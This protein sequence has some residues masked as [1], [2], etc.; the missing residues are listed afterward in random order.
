MSIKHFAE[1]LGPEHIHL[2]GVSK[3]VDLSGIPQTQRLYKAED[4]LRLQYPELAQ[5]SPSRQTTRDLVGEIV[6]H[7]ALDEV[8]GIENL[9]A[10]FDPE[11][12]VHFFFD[13]EIVGLP[14]NSLGAVKHHLR[15]ETIKASVLGPGPQSP[16]SPEYV[17]QE[18]PSPAMVLRASRRGQELPTIS[19][20]TSHLVLNPK[21]FGTARVGGTHSH[22]WTQARLNIHIIRNMFGDQYAN[23]LKNHYDSLGVDYGGKTI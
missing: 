5:Q 11:K 6:H 22:E 15:G 4:R 19:H 2:L 21:L 13:P 8:P 3:P 14:R 1:G 17:K 7:P 18:M 9:R 20:E 16:D 23:S 12:S 10:T